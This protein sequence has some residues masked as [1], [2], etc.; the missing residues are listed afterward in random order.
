MGGTFLIGRGG[1][2]GKTEHGTYVGPARFG[3][4]SRLY[5]CPA[6]GHR[7]VTSLPARSGTTPRSGVPRVSDDISLAT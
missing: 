7:D 2:S 4:H 1:G 6:K 5:G 3:R